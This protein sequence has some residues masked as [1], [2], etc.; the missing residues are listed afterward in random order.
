M[1]EH[2]L[3]LVKDVETWFERMAAKDAG[4]GTAFEVGRLLGAIL[5]LLVGSVTKDD[6]DDTTDAS[7]A[8]RNMLLIC[9][10]SFVSS[11]W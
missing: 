8:S 4:D 2:Y 3:T 9:R 7:N 1:E 11:S 10:V 6:M 5:S